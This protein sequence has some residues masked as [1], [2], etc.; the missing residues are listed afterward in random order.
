MLRQTLNVRRTDRWKGSGL[1][2]G[3]WGRTSKVSLMKFAC[4]ES[5]ALHPL[6][7]WWECLPPGTRREPFT[8][9]IWGPVSGRKGK[10]GVVKVDF[11]LLL[12]SQ[13]PS[14]QDSPYA[15]VPPC[16]G[17]CPKPHQRPASGR[18]S[19]GGFKPKSGCCE[20]KSQCDC[21]GGFSHFESR[22]IRGK[23]TV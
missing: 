18:K 22:K 19:Q 6:L 12:L 10:D 23:T 7:W 5:L 2:T 9:G 8:C 20:S 4:T 11:L 21:V 16:L 13:S 17:P 3:K 1:G 15:K 14:A